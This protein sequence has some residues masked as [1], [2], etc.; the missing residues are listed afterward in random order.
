VNEVVGGLRQM[1]NLERFAVEVYR[2]QIRAFPQKDIRERL[3]AARDNEQEH[4]DDLRAR[5][6]ELGGSCPWQGFFFQMA[7][8]VLGST[9][10]LLGRMFALNADIRLEQRAVRDYG[11]FL[12]KIDFDENSRRLIQKNIEDEKVHIKRWEDSKKIL[13]GEGVKSAI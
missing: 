7:G 11:A 6:E 12:Q 4:V 1:Y 3:E 2:R 10:T 5:I 9:S 8:M 13:K